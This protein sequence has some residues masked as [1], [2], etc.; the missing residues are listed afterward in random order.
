MSVASRSLLPMLFF[1]ALYSFSGAQES[2]LKPQLEMHEEGRW[3]L[4]YPSFRLAGS[5][6]SND[7][8]QD[9]ASQAERAR[10]Y[11]KR[12]KFY[13]AVEGPGMLLG[14]AALLV[15]MRYCYEDQSNLARCA[16]PYAG[17]ALILPVPLALNYLYRKNMRIALGIYNEKDPG[18][19]SSTTSGFKLS[20]TGTVP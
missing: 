10:P 16:V 6:I 7:S 18:S 3:G 19:Q 1:L 9:M 12:A 4:W 15:G 13:G 8:A 5:K 11:V 14:I 17:I 20:F 2:A